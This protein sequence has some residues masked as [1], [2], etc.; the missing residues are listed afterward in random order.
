MVNIDVRTELGR[1]PVSISK[2]TLTVAFLGTVTL[3][4]C[5]TLDDLDRQSYQ[6][7]CDNLGIQ[8]GTA[9]YDECMMQQQRLDNEDM[10]RAMDRAADERFRNKFK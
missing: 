7:A 9:T 5:Q 10:Q 8:R 1:E 4:G 3:A 6:R 2:A